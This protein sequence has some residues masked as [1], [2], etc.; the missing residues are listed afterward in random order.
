MNR[1]R[2]FGELTHS[3]Q[4]TAGELLGEQKKRVVNKRINKE[5]CA[6]INFTVGDCRYKNTGNNISRR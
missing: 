4:S 5:I 1:M 6:S 2:G 3:Q